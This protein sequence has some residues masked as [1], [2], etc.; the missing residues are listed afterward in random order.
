MPEA[1]CSTEE[2][3]FKHNYTEVMSSL[4]I[5]IVV[6]CLIFACLLEYLSL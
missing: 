3:V 1:I 4:P 6:S 5:I 2:K